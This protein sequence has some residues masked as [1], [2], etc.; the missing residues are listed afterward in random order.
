MED[1]QWVW[2]D[3]GRDTKIQKLTIHWETAFGKEYEIYKSSDNENWELIFKETDS[4]GGKDEIDFDELETRYFRIDFK[5]R[6]TQWG[7][8]I[9]EMEFE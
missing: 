1:P 2:I 8:S 7:Y 5:K 9:W 6:G 3:F 4:D